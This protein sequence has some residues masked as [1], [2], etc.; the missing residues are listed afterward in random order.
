MT[1]ETEAGMHDNPPTHN[2]SQLASFHLETR[3]DRK[4]KIKLNPRKAMGKWIRMG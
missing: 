3:I 1:P 2:S 4:L